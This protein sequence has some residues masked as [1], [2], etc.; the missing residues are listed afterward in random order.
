LAFD[1]EF[2]CGY[3]FPMNSIKQ[4]RIDKG[5]S[6][7][8]LARLAGTNQPQ[9]FKLE[10]SKLQLSKE[11]AE[12]LAPH[13][14]VSAPSLMF[15]H[16]P[17]LLGVA[18]GLIVEGS[19]EAGS[20][21]D[22]SLVDESPSEREV[23]PVARDQRFPHAHQ[24]SMIVSGDS[25]DAVVDE[26]SYVTCAA[27]ADLGLQLRPGMIL[28]VEKHIGALVENTLKRYAERDGKRWLDPESSNRKHLPIE[29]NGDESTEILIKGLMTGYWKPF[30]F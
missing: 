1:A 6:Q 5:L 21:R 14:G 4:L 12:R 19:V 3:P 28:H 2:L 7:A 16:P 30:D 13:L 11:W 29:I 23:I 10:K 18:P 24:Y 17:Q 15:G 8:E 25:M 20:F 26:G 22:V 9:I 27:W